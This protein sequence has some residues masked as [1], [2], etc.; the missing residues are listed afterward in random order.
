MYEYN[1]IKKREYE[2]SDKDLEMAV[3]EHSKSHN[4]AQFFG[5]GFDIP[6]KFQNEEERGKFCTLVR[7]EHQSFHDALSKELWTPILEHN[8]SPVFCI[9]IGEVQEKLD[10]IFKYI[11]ENLSHFSPHIRKLWHDAQNT[12][13]ERVKQQYI[14]LK[15]LNDNSCEPFD[16]EHV[17]DPYAAILKSVRTEYRQLTQTRL[18]RWNQITWHVWRLYYK[19]R[20]LR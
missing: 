16:D 3:R 6:D 18:E 10:Y 13:P 19:V 20:T 8:Q 9:E 2:S 14:S 7:D 1:N 4:M 15:T 17:E 11:G 5:I 12:T